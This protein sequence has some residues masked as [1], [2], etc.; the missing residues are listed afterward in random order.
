[1]KELRFDQKKD[2]WLRHTRG[3]GF[4]DII[5]AIN[6]GCPLKIIDHPNKKNHSNQ[7]FYLVTINNYI[8]V[9]PVVEEDKYSFMKT[10][11]P[12]RKYTKK[13]LKKL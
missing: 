6:Q 7:K 11:Y 10:I 4:N 12:S 3:I 1:M 9:I 13:Y 2:E 5:E 8:Y